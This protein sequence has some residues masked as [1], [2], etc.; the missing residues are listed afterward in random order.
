MTPPAAKDFAE[1]SVD[2]S[3]FAFTVDSWRA[4]RQRGL[5]LRAINVLTAHDHSGAS[6]GSSYLSYMLISLTTKTLH[7]NELNLK[8]CRAYAL[9]QHAGAWK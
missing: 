5:Q 1:E 3:R 7:R 2:H 4:P 6:A 8:S 9:K